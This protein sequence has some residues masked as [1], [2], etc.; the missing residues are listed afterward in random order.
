M[1]ETLFNKRE[2]FQLPSFEEDWSTINS[3][4]EVLAKGY[5]IYRLSEQEK[6]VIE[7]QLKAFALLKNYISVS[8]VD[9]LLLEK[10][11]IRFNLILL[12]INSEVSIKNRYHIKKE[13][14]VEYEFVS[15]LNLN[16][17]F[18]HVIIRPETF[19]DKFSELFKK[20]DIDFDEESEFSKKYFLSATDE[21]TIIEKFPRPILHLIGKQ[22]GVHIEI[23]DNQLVIQLKKRLTQENTVKI[24]H[25]ASQILENQ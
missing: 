5:K 25:L 13:N 16:Q 18:G 19:K 21:T 20:V 23:N 22:T 15:I 17:S 11:T 4:F 7:Q 8:F 24:A 14:T 12:K 9:A 10:D 6:L 2:L 1:I 3:A